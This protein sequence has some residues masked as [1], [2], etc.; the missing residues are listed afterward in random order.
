MQASLAAFKKTLA[1]L[2]KITFRETSRLA[3]RK[4]ALKR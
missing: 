1:T 4:G 2:R 3:H